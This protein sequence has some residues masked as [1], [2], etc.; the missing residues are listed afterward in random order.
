MQY[1]RYLVVLEFCLH[2]KSDTQYQIKLECPFGSLQTIPHHYNAT[3]LEAVV[4]LQ[5]GRGHVSADV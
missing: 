4:L 5:E 1:I 2:S 3:M